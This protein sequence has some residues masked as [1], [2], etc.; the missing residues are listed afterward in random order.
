MSFSGAVVLADLDDY[1]A[2]SQAC[3]LPPKSTPIKSVSEQES[4][5]CKFAG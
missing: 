4:A 2:P 1:I 3:I 5:L